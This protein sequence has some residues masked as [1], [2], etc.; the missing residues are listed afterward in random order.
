LNKYTRPGDIRFKPGG[1]KDLGSFLPKFTYG[2][3]LSA[4]WKGF[5]VTMFIQGVSGNKIYN[6][7]RVITEGMQRL[8]NSGTAVSNAWT[9]TNTNTD[10]PRAVNGDPNANARPSDRF[11]EDGSYLRI[12]NLSIG[13][14]LPPSFLSFTNGTV[15]RFRIYVTSQNLLTVTK[16]SGYDPEVGN[17]NIA[18]GANNFL[19]Q[20]ID[21]GQFPQAKTLL[22]GVQ[23]GF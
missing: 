4:T 8:F 9:P 18:N 3:N 14:T 19:T 13:Y 16:Y 22:G 1:P 10:I 7:T 5:D 11:L 20:G 2:L 12:K 15:K 21:Y 17:R 6:G 23:V